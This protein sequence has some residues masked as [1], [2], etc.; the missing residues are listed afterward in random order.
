[1]SDLIEIEHTHLIG[2]GSERNCYQHPENRNICIKIPY[3]YTAR[4]KARNAREVA[5]AIRYKSKNPKLGIPKYL[6]EIETNC[7]KGFQ[8]ELIRNHDGAV[9][10]QLSDYLKNNPPDEKL[11]QKIISLYMTFIKSNALVSDLHPGNLVMQKQSAQ[12]YEIIMIDGFGNSDFI[13]ICDYSR[14][15][16]KKKLIRKFKRMLVNI[17]LPTDGIH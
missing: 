7:G 10:K 5:Y 15:F 17:G 3:H 2:K 16:M 6:G 4:T 11:H 9:S 1:M 13:K 14:Y 12:E 8:F